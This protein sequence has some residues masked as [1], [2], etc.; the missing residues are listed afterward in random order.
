MSVEYSAE[1]A[2][3]VFSDLGDHH[4]QKR[5][6]DMMSKHS[7]VS[8]ERQ[9]KHEWWREVKSYYMHTKH[10]NIIRPDVQ[11]RIISSAKEEGPK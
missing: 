7:R 9:L 11:L 2:Q 6:F 4:E 1:A 10:D 3:A 8:F 5:Y